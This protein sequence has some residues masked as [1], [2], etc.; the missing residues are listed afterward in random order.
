MKQAKEEEETRHLCELNAQA[1]AGIK[2]LK[3]NSFK[4]R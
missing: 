2:E 1:L 4:E 3:E